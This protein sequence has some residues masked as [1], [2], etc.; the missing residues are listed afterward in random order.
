MKTI[1]PKKLKKG[2][3]V[4]I[5]SPSSPIRENFREKFNQGVSFLEKELGL[6]VKFGKHIFDQ[7]YY[8]AGTR[9]ARIEDFNAIWK[10]TE[11]KMILMSQGGYTANHL[12]DG[13][14]YEMIKN[15]PK[16]FA[17][18][19]DGTT[20]LNAIFAKTGLVTYHGPDLLWTF[21]LKISAVFREN[22]IK[23][24]FEG[25]VGELHPNP[26]WEHDERKD[27]SYDGWQCV[28]GGNATGVLV[29]G[30]L[31]CLCCTVLA[32]YGPNFKNKILFLE[33]TYDVAHLDR[34]LTA[35]KLRGVFSEI[36]GLILGW[37]EDHEMKEKDRNREVAD[38]V[39]E[40]T[41]NYS[42]PI[43]EIGELGH[44]VENYIFPIGCKATIDS[45]RKYL[46]IDEK[47]VIR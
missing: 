40:V 26:S 33:G 21:G 44:N 20:L 16:I 47:T 37:F 45:D 39:L 12:L 29:G 14:D 8:S 9:E 31:G 19:S 15:N 34:F 13:I 7:H 22:L 41:R 18:I 4:G 17:G 46:S 30:H 43:L 25:N 10:D 27:I 35:L 6:K 32:G 5:V 23:T 42:F 36:K 11:V 1:K 2:D 28:R 38:M 3:V 24:W